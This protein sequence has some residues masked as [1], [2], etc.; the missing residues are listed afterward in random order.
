ME[1]LPVPSV[2]SQ[3][4]NPKVVFDNPQGSF[5]HTLQRPKSHRS[6]HWSRTDWLEE[7]TAALFWISWTHHWLLHDYQYILDWSSHK[8]SV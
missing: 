8:T 2:I 3:L 5:P 1:I 7:H 6:S 4:L